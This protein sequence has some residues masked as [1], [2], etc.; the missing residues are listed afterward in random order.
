M[1]EKLKKVLPSGIGYEME[2]AQFSGN[3]LLPLLRNGRAR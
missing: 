2:I 3:V 1:L